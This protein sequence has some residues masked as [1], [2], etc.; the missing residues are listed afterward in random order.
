[1][2]ENNKNLSLRAYELIKKKILQNELDFREK[3][4][5]AEFSSELNLSRTPIREAL[6]MLEGE[7]LITR[8]RGSGFYIRQFSVKD[9]HDFYELRDILETASAYLIIS[10]VTNENIYELSKILEQVRRIIKKGNSGKALA[11]A[12]QFHIKTIEI[13]KNDMIIKCLKNCYDKLILMSWS[14]HQIEKSI[15]S[16]KEHEKIL[17]ALISKDLDE[18]KMSLH[19]HVLNGKE[20]TLD[21]LKVDTQRLYFV[22]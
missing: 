14:C 10:N 13:C 2:K 17:S 15:K 22:P 7:D 9:V 16:A 6:N 8:Y 1:M 11:A 12:M 21:V 5:E 3:L 4:S 19:Q 20:R 18:L